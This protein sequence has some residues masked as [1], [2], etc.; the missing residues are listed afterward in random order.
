MPFAEI[1]G[2]RVLFVHIP[3]TGGSSVEEWL[4]GHAP[5]N[6]VGPS[7]HLKSSAQHLPHSFYV[8]LFR[9]GWF[10]YA[11]TIVRDP[12]DRL[13]SEYRVRRGDMEK[14]G[15]SHPPAFGEWVTTQLEACAKNPFVLDNHVRPQIDF[16]G[17]G[18]EI[19]RFES[20]L[21]AVLDAVAAR[22]GLP[23]PETVPHRRKSQE[24]EEEPRWDAQSILKA[25]DFYRADFDLL[26]YPRRSPTLN[27]SEAAAQ[28]GRS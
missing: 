10:D 11:F 28:D 6:F 13:A 2:R 20:G 7:Q 22:L 8:T 25:N 27:L 19:F 21:R 23:P 18:V 14:R 12:Y 16:V 9:P 26:A 17:E 1:A 24:T 5:L 3:K 4:A 15:Y